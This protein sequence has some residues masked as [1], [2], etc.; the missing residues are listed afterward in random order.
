MRK[1]IGIVLLLLC[2]TLSSAQN[3]TETEVNQVMTDAFT[4]NEDGNY[5]TA[6]EGFLKVG[7]NTK[8]QR[9]EEERQVYVCSQTMAVFC[10]EQL[11]QYDEGFRL[12]ETLLQGNLLDKER[13]DIQHLYVM[14]GYFMATSFLKKTSRRYADAREILTKI[15]P[16]ANEDMKSRILPKIPMSWYFEGTQYQIGQEYDEA[17]SC[18]EKARKGFHEIGDSKD[19]LDAQCQ[20]GSIKGFTYDAWGAQEAYQQ[21]ESLA[22]SS[23][24]EVKLISILRE[25]RKISKQ[26]GN[27]ELS[28]RLDDEMDSLIAQSGNGKVKFEYYNY[29]GDE[30]KEQG[31]FLLAE[32]WYK[33]NEPYIQQ[34]SK[35][36]VGAER[37]IY[38]TNLRNLYAKTRKYQEALD[39][40]YKSKTVFQ[41]LNTEK[42]K[43]YYMP[44]MAIADIYRLM[45]DSVRCFQNLDTLFLSTNRLEEPKELEQL[46][47]T[48]ARSYSAFK[49]FDLALKDYQTADAL[50]GN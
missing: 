34:L 11:K 6:L 20:I 39:Y 22:R 49:R 18:I 45:G 28:S 10:Y 21:A 41:R 3:L 15:L 17:L 33:R 16:Y 32:S 47:I 29:K 9:T 36:Y 14:N 8:K 48:R 37:Y 27:T 46:Y 25:L 19:E 1:S 7:Q 42:D 43:N 26:I 38:Y 50:L 2:C 44:Y 5:Q 12:S 4:Q 40:A 23:G 13:E 35:E 31:Q 24:N 30:A